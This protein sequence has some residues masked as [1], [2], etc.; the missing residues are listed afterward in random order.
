MVKKKIIDRLIG[1]G[2][3]SGIADSCKEFT[4]FLTVSRKYRYHC[5]YVFHII[6]PQ[7]EIWQKSFH[8]QT[9]L[10]FSLV[11]YLITQLQKFYK[12][13]VFKKLPNMSLFILCG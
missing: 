2:N 1:M 13:I 4:D 8:K 9:F 3:V 11:V 6:I 12:I 10:I 5:V 7:R